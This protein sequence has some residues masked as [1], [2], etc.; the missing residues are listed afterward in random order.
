MKQQVFLCLLMLLFIAGTKGKEATYSEYISNVMLNST[1]I[2][3]TSLHSLRMIHT[4]VMLLFAPEH[5]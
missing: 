3:P 5:V 4:L 2:V 1:Q